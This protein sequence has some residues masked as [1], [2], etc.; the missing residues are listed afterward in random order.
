M[1]ICIALAPQ[2][3]SVSTTSQYTVRPGDTM[4]A[5][6]TRFGFAS[7]REIYYHPSNESFRRKR[8]NPDKIFVGDILQIPSHTTP[9]SDIPGLVPGPPFMQF[10]PLSYSEPAPGTNVQF[11]VKPK[12]DQFD[13]NYRHPG[14]LRIRLT[15]FWVTNCINMDSVASPYLART[16]ELFAK[17]GLGL[18]IYPSR[19]R[20]EQH[21]IETPKNV[22]DA[23][24]LMINSPPEYN[25]YNE[26]RW[27]AAKRYDDQK[28][29][30]KRQRLPVIFCEFRMPAKGVTVVGSPWPPYVLISGNLSPD[31]ATLA[32]EIIHAAGFGP[33]IP[34]PLNVMA[35]NDSTRHEIYRMHVE[36][37][38]KAYFTR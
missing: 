38:A 21:T 37:V 32:H 27:L 15:L 30:G 6:A 36:M 33:H 13:V 22:N 3:P 4:T 23:G 11:G 16:E 8:P 35:E 10:S 31:R 29:P 20:T 1:A 14:G 17:H 2:P 25:H 28:V 9:S 12:D 34:R 19:Q 24:G 18:D 26:V 7:W 5:I